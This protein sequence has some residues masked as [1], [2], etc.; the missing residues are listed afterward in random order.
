MLDRTGG[1]SG[2]FLNVHPCISA[3]ILGAVINIRV[4]RYIYISNIVVQSLIYR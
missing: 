1:N 3:C 2:L 4:D